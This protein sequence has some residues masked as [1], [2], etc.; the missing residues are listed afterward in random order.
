MKT[1]ILCGG[2]ND[3]EKVEFKR[4]IVTKVIMAILYALC[5]FWSLVNY[6]H[7]G[8]VCFGRVV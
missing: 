3:I 2:R 4:T 7:L 8:I 6:L 5:F 1:I